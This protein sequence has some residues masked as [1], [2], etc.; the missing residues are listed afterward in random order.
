VYLQAETALFSP[1]DGLGALGQMHKVVLC[2]RVLSPLLNDDLDP[3]ELALTQIGIY[4][5]GCVASSQGAQTFLSWWNHALFSMANIDGARPAV[6]QAFLDDAPRLFGAHVLSDPGYGVASWNAHERALR[7]GESGAYQV[8]NV[9]LRTVRLEGFDPEQPALL[10]Q[11]A[12]GHPRVLLSEHLVLANLCEQFAKDLRESEAPAILGELN[13]RKLPDGTVV[14]DR[15][16]RLVRRA[17]GMRA[18]TNN[19]WIPD[20]FVSASLPEFYAWLASPDVDDAVAPMLPRYFRE[21]YADRSDLQWHF[22]RVGTVDARH[23]RQWVESYGLIEEDI[24]LGLRS[25]LEQSRW[26]SAPTGAVIAPADQLQ[27]GV[28]FAGQLLTATGIGE[29]GRLVLDAFVRAGFE[30]RPI[31]T[32]NSGTAHDRTLSDAQGIADRATNIVWVNADQLP[33][34][35]SVIGPE[36]F[37]GRYT[38]GGWVWETDK[39]PVSMAKS[40]DLVDEIWVPSDYVRG[41]IEPVVDKPVFVFPHPVVEAPLP[42]SFDRSAHGIPPGFMF[43]FM[44]DFLSSFERKNPLAVIA[45]FEKAFAP[46]DGPILVVKSLNG[47]KHLAELERLRLFAAERADVIVVDH[48]FDSVTRHALLSSCDCYVSLHRSEGFGLVLAEA[49]ALAKPVVATG[50]SGNLQFMDEE[51]AYLVPVQ[52]CRVGSH[53]VPYEQDGM[54]ANPDID[55]AAAHMRRIYDAPDLAQRKGE[56]ARRRVLEN[57]GMDRAV[58]FVKARMEGIDSLRREGYVSAV[59]EAAR[60]RL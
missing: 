13:F 23:F 40:A 35:A 11:V 60:M 29:A 49:M 34:F 55:A 59:A 33:G 41:A 25:A 26:W 9:P 2:P 20:P 19:V 44:F 31:A 37:D 39:L 16:R 36:F 52:M 32:E 3:D 53:A 10:S 6:A 5:F 57:F 48:R 43:L 24:C 18:A 14:D 1:L 30:V 28:A 50:Y 51:T 4:D 17:R 8:E 54:W 58:Q 46:E 56:L 7:Q 27:P 12:R 42:A 38:V 45:A 15:M 47:D 22:P 21:V